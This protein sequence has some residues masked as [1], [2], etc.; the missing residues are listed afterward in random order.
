MSR[1]TRLSNEHVVHDTN[2]RPGRIFGH[3]LLVTN[4]LGTADYQPSAP[5]SEVG[6]CGRAQGQVAEAG[7]DNAGWVV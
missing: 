5:S 1:W 2:K 7:T 3:D 4:Y 6:A